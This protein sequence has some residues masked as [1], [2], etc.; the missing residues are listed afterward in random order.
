MLN[1]HYKKTAVNFNDSTWY[2]LNNTNGNLLADTPLYTIILKLKSKTTFKLTLDEIEFL[3]SNHIR[4]VILFSNQQIS[5]PEYKQLSKKEQNDRSKQEIKPSSL[6]RTSRTTLQEKEN[7]PIALKKYLELKEQVTSSTK[8][9]SEQYL[10]AKKEVQQQRIES[11]NNYLSSP[12]YKKDLEDAN[13]VTEANKKILEEERHKH[14]IA[15]LRRQLQQKYFNHEYLEFR[16]LKR[17]TQ[18]AEKFEKSLRISKNDA[19]WVFSHDELNPTNEFL[20]VYHCFEAKDCIAEYNKTKNKWKLINA[21]SQYRKGLSSLIAK[22]LLLKY[23]FSDDKDS[24]LRSAYHTTFGGVERD[25][26]NTDEAIKHADTA[27]KIQPRNFRPCTL[28]GA[29]YMVSGNYELGID[30]YEKA[31]ER[32]A[33]ERGINNE[34]STIIKKLSKDEQQ[35][36]LKAI[37]IKSVDQYKYLLRFVR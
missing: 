12:Q 22:D 25:L 9:Y 26:G 17:I 8:K 2:N 14:E 37:R 36:M 6:I 11:H 13:Q 16:D 1:R 34:L 3:K 35:K 19:I 20:K 7:D 32:G 5:F 24:K 10:N 15:R 33:P 23:N 27:H 30:W 31:T 21:S 28:L 18:I 29:V 4:S